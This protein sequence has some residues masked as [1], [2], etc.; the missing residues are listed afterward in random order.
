MKTECAYDYVKIGES[1]KLCG[2]YGQQSFPSSMCYIDE[3][4][5]YYPDRKP[6][7]QYISSTIRQTFSSFQVEEHSQCKY[8]SASIYDGGDTNA[9]LVVCGGRLTAESSPGH[10]YSHATFSDSKYGKSQDCWWK[11]SARSRQR[12]VRIQFNAFTLEAE[13]RCQYDYVEVYDGS[14]PV[15]NRLFGRFCGDSIPDSITSTGPEILLILH[16]DDSEEEKGFVAEY[17]EAPRGRIRPAP[18]PTLRISNKEPL[19]F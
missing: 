13:E 17:R 19:N 18:Q 12:G 16:T 7:P 11:I 4:T 5:C 1:E 9:P 15:Q 6:G 14:E 2:D 3:S 10:I 8:D